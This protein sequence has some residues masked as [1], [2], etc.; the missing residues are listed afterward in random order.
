MQDFF[1][2]LVE[3]CSINPGNI[4]DF[5]AYL[6]NNLGVGVAVIDAETQ[7]V[8]F[9]NSEFLNISGYTREEITSKTCHNLLCATETGECPVAD[10]GKIINNSEEEIIRPDG[11][12]KPIIKSVAQVNFANRTYFIESLTDNSERKAV[13]DQLVETNEKLKLEINKRIDMQ[14]QIKKVAYHDSLT[15]LPN[16]TL[17]SKHLDHAI[18]QACRAEVSLAIMLLH[19]DD[20]R[21]LNNTMAKSVGNRLLKE[22]T[23]RLNKTL[24]K[25]D[26][27]ARF[28]E[29]ELIILIENVVNMDS[30]DIISGKIIGSLSQPLQFD[31]L[32]I[33]I[34]TSMGIAVYPTDGTAA[35]DLI[36]NAVTAVCN[37][38][39]KG[40]NQ[41]VLRTPKQ[42]NNV[43]ESVKL[44]NQLYRAIDKNELVLY[45]QPQI[46]CSSNEIN[47]LEALIR[48]NHPEFGLIHPSKFIPIADQISFIDTIGEWVIRT[49]CKQ[50][51]EWQRSGLPKI[52][53]SVNLSLQQFQNPYIVEQIQN[54]LLET[55]LDPN[56]LELE[57]KENVIM[58]E[59]EE[60]AQ[61]LLLLRNEGI[62]ITIDDFSVKYPSLDYLKQISVDKI[63]IESP[64]VE[65]ID[66]SRIEEANIKNIIEQAKQMGLR[67]LAKG[68]ETEAQLS[69]LRQQK[70]DEIQGDLYYAAMPAEL[71]KKLL[72][73]TYSQDELMII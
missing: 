31:D 21:R 33:S 51:R 41:F 43:L 72:K 1:A 20:I 58:Y 6:L 36:K 5:A 30:L 2:P 13:Q 15:G 56:Y 68:V 18:A 63:K 44:R 50:N 17:F 55:D 59:T 46:N 39:E 14:E 9:V 62:T 42:I 35:N 66:Y 28:G 8:I 27:I 54:I 32:D 60:I 24:R 4:P 26:I 40:Q 10:L 64:F 37:A 45:Y 48:W 22:V 65:S 7:Q 67:V 23:E 47:G 71:V 19:L 61:T 29:D 52:P 53:V 70:C 38:M 25:S 3:S 16:S 49:A 12:A 57:I 69:F 73:I 11:T 34:S